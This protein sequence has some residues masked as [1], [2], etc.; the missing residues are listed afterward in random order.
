M[1]FSSASVGLS[2]GTFPFSISTFPSI[3]CVSTPLDACTNFWR[4]QKKETK[5]KGT[6]ADLL[7]QTLLQLTSA[8]KYGRNI[9]LCS[10]SPKCGNNGPLYLCNDEPTGHAKAGFGPEV[11][12]NHDAESRLRKAELWWAGIHHLIHHHHWAAAVNLARLDWR[13]E[14][15]N[16]SLWGKKTYTTEVIAPKMQT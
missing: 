10:K 11:A 5:S 13:D 4:F 12:G 16:W 2:S 9:S 7:L 6:Q 3:T 15:T 14:G 8:D 1:S